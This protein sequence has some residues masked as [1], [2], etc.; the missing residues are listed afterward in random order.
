MKGL[1]AHTYTLGSKFARIILQDFALMV[2]DV[3]LLSLTFFFFFFCKV[4]NPLLPIRFCFSPRFDPARVEDE[5]AH[6]QQ[7]LLRTLQLITS[8]T[9]KITV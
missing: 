6:M 4:L 2:L 9:D 1:I 8:K 7:Q 5:N 3:H